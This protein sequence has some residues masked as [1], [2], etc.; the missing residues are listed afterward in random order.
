MVKPSAKELENIKKLEE[1]LA[2]KKAALIVAKG[3]IKER[4]KKTKTRLL[5]EIGRLADIAGIS[6]LDKSAILGGFLYLSEI[7]KNDV[8]HTKFKAEGDKVLESRAAERN[9]A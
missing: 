7:V 3:R 4:E 6:E 1:Q 2:K 9:K 5:I 8:T